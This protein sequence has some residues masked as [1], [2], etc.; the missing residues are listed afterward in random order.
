[1]DLIPVRCQNCSAPLEIPPDVRFV[2]CAHCGSPLEVRHAGSASYTTIL[3]KVGRKVEESARDVAVIRLQNELERIDREWLMAREGFMIDTKS[4]KQLPSGPWSL[5]AL[6]PFAIIFLVILG[7]SEMPSGA[8]W[9]MFIML[10]LVVFNV[11]R[12][13][14][15]RADYDQA[16]AVYTARHRAL[17]AALE[18]HGDKD[19]P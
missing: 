9:F 2:T 1:M 6:I 15:K 12:G 5:L 17:V 14:S 4:G 7:F 8:G 16:E 19:R 10:G 18:D 3:E 13:I 11:V